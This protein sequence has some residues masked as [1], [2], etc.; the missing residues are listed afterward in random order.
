MLNK[1]RTENGFDAG[2]YLSSDGTWYCNGNGNFNDVYIRSDKRSKEN[3]E[4]ISDAGQK[5]SKLS[6][7]TYTVSDDN[8]NSSRS[9]G[10]IAQEVQD[11]LPEAVTKDEKGLLR[12]N[13]NSVIG[14]LVESVKD[15][16][17]QVDDL[18]NNR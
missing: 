12:L 10:L 2:A 13:Y 17:K 11:I 7:Y 15:L 3:I 6:G 9:A 8:N 5:L 1:G 4:K 14:L 18:K 16:Q